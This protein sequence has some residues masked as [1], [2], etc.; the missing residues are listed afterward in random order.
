[1]GKF[2]TI[3]TA[4]IHSSQ[5]FLKEKTVSYILDRIKNGDLDALPPAPIVR[6][7]WGDGKY[8]AID[9]HNLIAVNDRFSTACAVYVADSSE[10]KLASKNANPD[11]V[12][13]R[14]NDLSNKFESSMV[15]AQQLE[16]TGLGT[17]RQLRQKYSALA[18]PVN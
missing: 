9:G 13:A 6:K 10:D 3:A 5:D 8:V 12:E 15:E 18:D 1:M 16:S 4:D 7:G 11:S 14:N 2:I 17:F